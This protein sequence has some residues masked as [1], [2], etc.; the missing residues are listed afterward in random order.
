MIRPF[1]SKA[2]KYMGNAMSMLAMN[3]MT[4]LI[5]ALDIMSTKERWIIVH[6]ILHGHTH[7][8]ELKI[9]CG[10]HNSMTLS[11]TLIFLQKNGILVR[12]VENGR[13]QSIHYSLTPCGKDLVHVIHEMEK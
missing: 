3:N 12:N 6:C 2:I 1:K 8:N 5:K 7:F 13:P 11:R 4:P 9:A 10:S